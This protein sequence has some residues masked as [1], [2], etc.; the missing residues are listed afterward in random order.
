MRGTTWLIGAAVALAGLALQGVALQGVALQGVARQGVAM[1]AE[2]TSGP[3]SGPTSQPAAVRVV[4]TGT[5][6][7]AKMGALLLKDGSGADLWIGGL[8]AW[9]DALVGQKVRVEGILVERDD[10]P[11]VVYR[12]GEP[13]ATGVPVSDLQDIAAARRRT[14]ISEATWTRVE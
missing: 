6:Q 4:V 5:A 14:V 13:I 12:P 2:P 3:A 1:A 11:V 8:D 7:N 10:V 9:P